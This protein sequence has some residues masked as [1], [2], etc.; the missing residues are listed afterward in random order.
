MLYTHNIEKANEGKFLILF[1]KNYLFCNRPGS[2]FFEDYYYA[3]L[4][5]YFFPF[6]KRNPENI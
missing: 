5:F 4:I 3:Y 2:G 1:E 6:F